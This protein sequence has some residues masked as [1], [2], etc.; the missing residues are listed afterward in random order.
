MKG[1]VHEDDLFIVHDYC[2]SM[3]VKETITWMRYN[4][5]FH[6]QFLPMNGF[7]NGTPY[8][9]LLVGNSPKL[10]H[11]DNILN[12]YILHSYQFHCVLI[13][14]FLDRQGT[15][16]ENR[17]MRISLSTPNKIARGLKLILEQKM[18]TTS[19]AR[20]IQDVDL[21]LK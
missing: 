14:F 5:Y 12:I 2:V 3:T 19:S 8:S 21:E 4:N 10:I 13:R 7:K 6:C 9:G 17:N 18:G 16:K 15:N 1:Y 20:I 11:L